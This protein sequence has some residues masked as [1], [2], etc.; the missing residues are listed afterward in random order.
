[1]ESSSLLCSAMTGLD[2]ESVNLTTLHR[3][4]FPCL[5]DAFARFTG[6][7]TLFTAISEKHRA[8]V[9]MARSRSLAGGDSVR[10]I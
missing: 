7:L 1:M 8:F 4:Q 5:L 3:M 10:A 6:V 9:F 2:L